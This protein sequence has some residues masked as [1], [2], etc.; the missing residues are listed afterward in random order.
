MPADLSKIGILA[1]REIEA[2]IL[3]PVIKEFIREIGR[4][5]TLAIL[6]PIIKS[7]AREAG[8]QL[9]K[10]TGGISLE[11]FMKG[12]SLWT[13]DDALQ[14]RI[15]EETPKK[16]FFDVTRCRYAEMYRDLGIPEFGYLLSC[17]RDGA[18]IEGYNPK[19]SFTRTKTIMEG[20]DYCDFRYELSG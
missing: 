20:A 18:L 16:L 6:E 4:E 11:H 19:I 8:N 14:L 7:L 17:N 9:A 13:M 2:R 12:L 10:I 3:A 15:I 1:R 5:R